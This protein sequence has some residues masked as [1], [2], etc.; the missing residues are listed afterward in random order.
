MKRQDLLELLDNLD[1][2]Y[3]ELDELGYSTYTETIAK[4]MCLICDD[5]NIDKKQFA[6]LDC[7]EN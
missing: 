5:Y 4:T 1:N 2:V 7:F 3:D 6:A